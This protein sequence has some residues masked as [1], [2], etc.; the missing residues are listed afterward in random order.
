MKTPLFVCLFSFLAFFGY[1]EMNAKENCIDQST[2]ERQT[3][4]QKIHAHKVAY[5]TEK[6]A[7]TPAE[8]E[9]FW[10]LYNTYQHR[11]E[12]IMNEFIQK[13][14]V[15]KEGSN[16]TEFDVSNLSEA[17]VKKLVSDRARLIDLERK[18]HADLCKLFTDPRRVLE[19]YEAEREFQR[20]LIGQHAR[21]TTRPRV[22]EP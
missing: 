17:E 3:F 14:R 5:F 18:F 15:K 16:K 9:K 20:E 8:A 7:L 11:R 22:M 1:S 2:Q 21:T 13:T 6:M 12:M 19:F 10:P 4:K